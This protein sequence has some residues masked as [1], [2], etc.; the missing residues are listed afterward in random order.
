MVMVWARHFK[1]ESAL[2]RHFF[3]EIWRK[4]YNVE[5]YIY[6]STDLTVVRDCP[7]VEPARGDGVRMQNRRGRCSSTCMDYK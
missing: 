7:D 5:L 3:C 1:C 4:L 2:F 6:P